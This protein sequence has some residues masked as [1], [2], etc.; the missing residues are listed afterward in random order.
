MK[1]WKVTSPI[2][3]C[4][5]VEQMTDHVIKD[6]IDLQQLRDTTQTTTGTFQKKLYNPNI[7]HQQLITS[8]RKED[9]AEQF[10]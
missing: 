5:V 8:E 1:A 6:C 7:V 2:C 3:P 10:I 4:G 9:E